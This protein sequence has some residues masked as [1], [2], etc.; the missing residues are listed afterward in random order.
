[1][2]LNFLYFTKL[3]KFGFLKYLYRQKKQFT[4]IFLYNV[5]FI[6][7]KKQD[8]KNKQKKFSM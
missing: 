1:M 2:L 7:G 5:K 6:L 4:N 8:I 3:E